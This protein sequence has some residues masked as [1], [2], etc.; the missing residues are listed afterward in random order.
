LSA[1]QESSF[2]DKRQQRAD[3]TQHSRPRSRFRPSTQTRGEAFDY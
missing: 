1:R 3:K 2:D